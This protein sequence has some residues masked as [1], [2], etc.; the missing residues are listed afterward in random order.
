MSLASLSFSLSS[1]RD[2]PTL[3]RGTADAEGRR[4]KLSVPASESLYLSIPVKAE[5]EARASGP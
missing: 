5:R 1:L 3:P 2:L 4:E